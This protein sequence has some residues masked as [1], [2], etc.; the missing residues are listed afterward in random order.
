MKSNTFPQ[1]CKLHKID[2]VVFPELQP[3]MWSQYR[4]YRMGKTV[5]D[6]TIAAAVQ[7][8]KRKQADEQAGAGMRGE[9][10]VPDFGVKIMRT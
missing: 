10:V 3:V 5:T 7:E 1:F 9:I 6:K 4:L 2:L 8:F